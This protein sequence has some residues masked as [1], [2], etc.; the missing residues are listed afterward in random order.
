MKQ[1]TNT[2]K[3][4]DRIDRLPPHAPEM[5][6]GA[7]GCQLKD[8]NECIPIVIEKHGENAHEIHYDLRHQT[9]QKAL[10]EMHMSMTHIDIISIQQKLK[11]KKMFEQVGGFGYLNK[12]EMDCPSAANLAYYLEKVSETYLLR[13][14]IATCTE[15][16][17][18]IYE[19]E[20]DVE[21]ALERFETDALALRKNQQS[22]IRSMK[23]LVSESLQEIEKVI[24]NPNTISGI[25]T[26][27]TDLDMASDGLHEGE[28]IVL[29]AYP[30]VGKTSLAMNIVEHVT[31]V[32]G[33]PVGVF[34]AEM[35]AK[36]LVKR[37]L[38]STARVSL[39]QIRA[40][41]ATADQVFPKLTMAAGKMIKAKLFIDDSSNLSVGQVR[42]RARRMVQQSGV[43]LFIADYAQLF[44]SPKAENR[45]N[46][47]DQISKGFKAMARELNVPVILLSQL[48]DEGKLK[49]ARALGEDADGVWK[50]S[51][52]E[53]QDEDGDGEKINL[54]LDK[55]RNDERGIN[56][57]LI[58]LK[59]YT[60]FESAS[61]FA[62]DDAK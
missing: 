44:T 58:F 17:G 29:A 33:L 62:D 42:A 24:E 56:I 16:I 54:F 12:L 46:E 10:I 11:E 20:A 4:S 39:K 41:Y 61:K 22:E 59:T 34:S 43:K 7:L 8:P 40:G 38:C 31:Q 13:K 47:I 3:A 48:N 36:S 26:G 19:N 1:I 2:K 50:L 32:L 28:F 25:S 55:Q 18:R 35:T 49:G 9:I 30:S 57:P 53:K 14:I 5:E 60:R 21:N 45:T 37:G 6:Q 15:T 51:R 27:F 23:D 52:D